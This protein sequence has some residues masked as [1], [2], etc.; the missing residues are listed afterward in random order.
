MAEWAAALERGLLPAAEGAWPPPPLRGALVGAL[1]RL[2]VP[3]LAGR[4]P[5]VARAVIG[6]AL[7]LAV[8]L[9][10]TLDESAP[11]C[12]VTVFELEPE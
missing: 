9:E 7:E 1:A 2:G 6:A 11:V 5:G 10:A 4:Y 12:F 8:E 3:D